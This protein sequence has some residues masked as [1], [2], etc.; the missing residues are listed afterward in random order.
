VFFFSFFSLKNNKTNNKACNCYT[1][2]SFSSVC[3]QSTGYCIC[4]PGYFGRDCSQC[5][6]GRYGPNCLRIIFFSYFLFSFILSYSPIF[7]VYFNQWIFLKT[8]KECQNCGQGTCNEGISGSGD[9]SCD[10]GWKVTFS[11]GKCD[12][13]EYLRYGSDC[14]GILFLNFVFFF[15]SFF[16]SFFFFFFFPYL[17]FLLKKILKHKRNLSRMWTW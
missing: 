1:P 2:G 4:K 9:C 12:K 5:L 10:V 7:I 16:F 14:S 17:L 13:C 8:K 11:G 3:E 6:P 15:F